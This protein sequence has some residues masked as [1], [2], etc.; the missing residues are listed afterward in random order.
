MHCH[1][2][3]SFA[4]SFR[5]VYSNLTGCRIGYE[6]IEP[7]FDISNMY[8]AAYHILSLSTFMM[9]ALKQAQDIPT[10]QGTRSTGSLLLDEPKTNLTVCLYQ[11]NIG[12]S[13]LIQGQ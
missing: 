8:P 13:F 2:N 7:N 11:I 4:K 3:S 6:K 1:V 5:N 9:T 12:H 10:N